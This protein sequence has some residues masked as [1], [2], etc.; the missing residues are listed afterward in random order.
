MIFYAV[1]DHRVGGDAAGGS[2]PCVTA[3]RREGRL[4]WL[5]RPCQP[6]FWVDLPWPDLG[7]ADRVQPVQP[8]IE[9]SGSQL[10]GRLPVGDELVSVAVAWLP[11]S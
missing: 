10:S 1:P 4:S 11:L 9:P 6:A 8:V 7:Q 5:R 3:A 2:S